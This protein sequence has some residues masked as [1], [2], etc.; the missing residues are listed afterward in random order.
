MSKKSGGL[1]QGVYVLGLECA[2]T[3]TC[4]SLNVFMN[5]YV[6][7]INEGLLCINL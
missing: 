2:E 1:D 7:C 6:H 5:I 4:V 3:E